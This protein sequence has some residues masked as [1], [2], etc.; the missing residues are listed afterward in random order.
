M[1]D[2][3]SVTFNK[4][5]NNFNVPFAVIAPKKKKTDKNLRFNLNNNDA[6]SASGNDPYS[7]V[8]GK[9]QQDLFNQD[10]DEFADFA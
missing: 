4:S 2:S 3:V 10:L 7:N 1:I 5:T 8:I 6:Y 9:Q